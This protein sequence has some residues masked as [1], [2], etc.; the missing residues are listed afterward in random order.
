MLCKL[1]RNL[2]NS[3]QANLAIVIDASAAHKHI[4]IFTDRNDPRDNCA[5]VLQGS[6]GFCKLHN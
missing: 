2:E 6:A 1:V 4:A 5:G 3:E